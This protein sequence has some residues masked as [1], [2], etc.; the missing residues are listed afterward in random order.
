M[1]LRGTPE[2][3]VTDRQRASPLTQK[4]IQA[5]EAE[6]VTVVEMTDGDRLSVLS[7]HDE[8]R[9]GPPLSDLE[10][11]TGKSA[12]PTTGPRRSAAT[13]M[14]PL[15]AIELAGAASGGDFTP[16]FA[17]PLRSRRADRLVR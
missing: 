15:K 6:L 14:S 12:S 2:R 4:I 5:S 3:R 10:A 16:V 9:H 17:A 7:N 13:S 1:A 11:P 8:L